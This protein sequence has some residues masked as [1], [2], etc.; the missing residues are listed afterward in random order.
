LTKYVELVDTVFLFLKKK[1]LQ[2]LHVYH[3][4]ATA[5]LCF[6]QLIGHTSVVIIIPFILQ[7]DLLQSYVPITLNLT[8]HVVMYWYYFQAARGVRVWWK[9]WVTRIQIIQF[10]V[11]LLFVY[12]ASYTY[13]PFPPQSDVAY[14]YFT[15]NYFPWMPNNGNCAG[16]E[17]AAIFGC[18]L[19]TSYLFLFIGFYAATYQR[20]GRVRANR[21]LS[22]GEIAIDP[23]F[24]DGTFAKNLYENG[25]DT[26]PAVDTAKSTSTAN[27]KTSATPRSRRI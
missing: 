10:V 5:V 13:Y 9:E 24:T 25:R 15:S 19:L 6:T 27:G 1:P 18:A 7:S 4:G 2:F 21:A 8:V 26:P 11:D 22:S 14:S 17:F 16:E 20:K 3:H 12:F 23:K